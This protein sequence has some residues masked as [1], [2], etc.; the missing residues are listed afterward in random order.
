MNNKINTLN[1]LKAINFLKLL[2]D[3]LE[4]FFLKEKILNNE[5]NTLYVASIGDLIA[6]LRANTPLYSDGKFFNI[7]GDEISFEEA[8]KITETIK[9]K[10]FEIYRNKLIIKPIEKIEE[11]IFTVKTFIPEKTIDE[12]IN[13]LLSDIANDE[14]ELEI[15]KNSDL[16][17]GYRE[18]RSQRISFT[19]IENIDNLNV[20]YQQKIQNEYKNL[21][22]LT[23]SF[24]NEIDYLDDENIDKD[25]HLIGFSNSHSKILEYRS[26]IELFSKKR[27]ELEKYISPKQNDFELMQYLLQNEIAVC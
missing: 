12:K 16:L 8:E 21:E 27:N 11:K 22:D 3:F 6:E 2:L 13:S 14:K 20:L 10:V 7:H 9:N 24:M 26:Q 23:R 15:T 17:S 5:K 19:I 4:D 25:E 1:L 18:D